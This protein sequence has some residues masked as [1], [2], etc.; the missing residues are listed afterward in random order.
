LKFL[1]AKSRQKKKGNRA[2]GAP[3][4]VFLFFAAR[5]GCVKP[6]L[7]KQGKKFYLFCFTLILRNI[8]GISVISQPGG[9]Q[10][11]LLRKRH[12]P[13]RELFPPYPFRSTPEKNIPRL[14]NALSYRHERN[15]AANGTN[16]SENP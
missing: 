15:A 13:K 12:R 2:F 6:T 5:V 8:A 4:A 9:I 7:Q 3:L 11:A 16:G 10:I 14:C 1:S